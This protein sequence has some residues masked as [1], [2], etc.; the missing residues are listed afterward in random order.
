MTDRDPSDIPRAT[1]IIPA[2]NEEANIE[3]CVRSIAA[4]TY[5][6]QQLEIIV[7]DDNSTDATASI[8]KTIMVDHANVRMISAGQLPEGWAGK[9]HACWQGIQKANG[10]WFC[11]I[12]AD[13]TSEPDLLIHAITFSVEKQIDLLSINPYQ[14]IVSCAERLF[15][16]GIFLSI[17]ATMNFNRVNDTSTDDSGANGQFMLF[18]KKAYNAVGGH[19]TVRSRIMEDM[20][21]AELIKNSG[22]RL[23]W[24][25]GEKL[26]R[27]RMYSNFYQIWEG[28]SKNMVDIT[29]DSGRLAPLY[30]AISSLVI[31]WTPLIMP[32]LAWKNLM[33]HGT[34]PLHMWTLGISMT[35]F[36]FFFVFCL[37]TLKA[38]DVPLRYILSFPMGFTLHAALTV[39]S[40]RKLAQGKRYWKGRIYG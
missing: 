3:K 5:P 12:D 27:T 11:F 32:F 1:V 23:Y 25:F 4:Q 15:M 9:N 38:L 24:V 28:L 10:E 29:K 16:P 2:R 7:V 20:A 6:T 33:I 14:E 26:I 18:R 31:G 37:L 40:V 22:F 8:V 17:A 35:A 39:N 30:R 36:F 13:T 21:L 34:S 19:Q